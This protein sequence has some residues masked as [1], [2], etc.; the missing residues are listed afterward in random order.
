[1]VQADGFHGSL[2]NC[3][4]CHGVTFGTVKFT[5]LDPA[6]CAGAVEPGIVEDLEEQKEA[7]ARNLRFDSAV[8]LCELTQNKLQ[9][10]G[11][12][13]PSLHNVQRTCPDNSHWENLCILIDQRI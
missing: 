6:W 3:R 5:S 4:K 10:N 2:G 9:L 1:M 7:L 8:R 13:R 11:H 12:G